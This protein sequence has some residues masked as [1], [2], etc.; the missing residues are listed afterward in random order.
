MAIYENVQNV[1]LL[2]VPDVP[3]WQPAK[4][5]PLAAALERTLRLKAE[6]KSMEAQAA[7]R[8]QEVEAELEEARQVAAITADSS[9]AAVAAATLTL[10]RAKPIIAEI[11]RQAYEQ[12]RDLQRRLVDVKSEVDQAALPLTE[13][14]GWYNQHAI[15]YLQLA[16]MFSRSGSKRPHSRWIDCQEQLALLALHGEYVWRAYEQVMGRKYRGEWGEL[17]PYKNS[18]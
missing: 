17:F 2:K 18:K 15:R 11:D 3:E 8:R 9:P 14:I 1:Q 4:G 10:E 13:T 7:G 16:K 12:R 6:Q 5:S